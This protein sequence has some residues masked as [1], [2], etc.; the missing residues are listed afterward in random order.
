MLVKFSDDLAIESPG[1][2]AYTKS[3]AIESLA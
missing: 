1:T 3:C 2:I